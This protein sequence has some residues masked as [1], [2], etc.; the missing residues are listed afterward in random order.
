MTPGHR[1]GRWSENARIAFA[2][3]GGVGFTLLNENGTNNVLVFRPAC[4]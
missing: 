4:P 2:K 3:S 1:L